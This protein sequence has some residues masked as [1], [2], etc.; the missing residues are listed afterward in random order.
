[1]AATVT[2]R[3]V[4]SVISEYAQSEDEVVATLV[5]LV[6]SGRIRLRGDYAGAHIEVPPRA[7]LASVAPA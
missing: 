2:L 1:M 6:N 5:H 7:P 3:E 4:V